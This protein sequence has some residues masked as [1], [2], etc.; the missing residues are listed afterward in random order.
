MLK[1]ISKKI[2]GWC[3]A[4]THCGDIEVI[5]YGVE[6]ILDTL[7]KLIALILLSILIGYPKE[8]VMVLITFSSLRFFAGGFHMHSGIGCFLSMVFIF[9]LSFAVEKLVIF[10]DIVITPDALALLLLILVGF[11]FLYA[12]RPTK[13]NPITDTRILQR[14]KIYSVALSGILCFIIWYMKG[15]NKLWILVPFI[16]EIVTILPIVNYK[17]TREED[18]KWKKTQQH[19]N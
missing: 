5:A 15:N 6:I 17:T 2:A 16:C 1:R 18:R 3:Y 4:K 7:T 8:M 11:V 9:G 12:P 14:K 10:Y 19:Q 13:N